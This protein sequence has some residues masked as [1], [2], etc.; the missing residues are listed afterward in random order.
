MDTVLAGWMTY[1]AVLLIFGA[2]QV[3]A[4]YEVRGWRRAVYWV[5]TG[6]VTLSL[7]GHY[8]YLATHDITYF[9][10]FPWWFSPVIMTVYVLFIAFL[11]SLR[12][13]EAQAGVAAVA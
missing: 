7:P 5:V 8:R 11:L 6:Y 4:H 12:P 13:R 1:C 10:F 3:F 9:Q 2:R